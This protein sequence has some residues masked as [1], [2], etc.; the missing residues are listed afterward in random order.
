MAEARGVAFE[1]NLVPP[2]AALAVEDHVKM[3]FANLV[4]NAVNYS[5]PGGCVRVECSPGAG[6]GPE[7]A[8]EDQDGRRAED[9]RKVQMLPVFG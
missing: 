7:V 6:D 9:A 1:E 2:C 3:I 5:K 4:A 8:I